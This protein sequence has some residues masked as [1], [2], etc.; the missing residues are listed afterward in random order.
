MYTVKSEQYFHVYTLKKETTM[1]AFT[2]PN[3]CMTSHERMFVCAQ[4]I[5]TSACNSH[6]LRPLP[7]DAVLGN[8]SI[9]LMMQA[10]CLICALISF[11]AG[12]T[13]G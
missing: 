13:L 8:Q 3:E 12:F 4:S 2:L 7:P 9:D 5:Q 6:K 10:G 11:L 1:G